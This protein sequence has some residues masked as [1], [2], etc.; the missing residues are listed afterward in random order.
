MALRASRL[1]GT[2]LA[3]STT[4]S[5]S[6]GGKPFRVAVCGAGPS[7][8]YATGRI[9]SLPGSEK[10]RVDLFEQLPVPFGLSRYGV[11]PDHPEVKVP[12]FLLASHRPELTRR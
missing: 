10:T 4:G 2:R 9:L 12:S 3:Y 5:P 1:A 7:G 8:F 6:L 11:A